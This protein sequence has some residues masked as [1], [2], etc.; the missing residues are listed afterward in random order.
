MT[1][2]EIRRWLGVTWPDKPIRPEII[3]G[4]RDVPVPHTDAEHIAVF[5]AFLKCAG[6]PARRMTR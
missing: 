5:R 4:M 3:E 2:Q 1:E 6:K